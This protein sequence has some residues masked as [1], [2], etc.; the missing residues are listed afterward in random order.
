MKK[1]NIGGQAVIEGVMMKS[2]D[3]IAIAVRRSDGTIQVDAKSSKPLKEKYPILGWPIVRGAVAFIE[4]MVTGVSSLMTS[5]ELYGDEAEEEYQPSKFEKFLADKFGK[6]V[7]N[8]MI[9]TS[10]VLAILFATLLFIVLPTFITNFL[11]G[12]I[13]SSVGMNL[14]EG[15]VRLLIFL[16]YIISISQIKDI[17]RVFEYHGAEHKTIHCYEHG[18]ELVVEN[19]RKYTT[20]HPRCGTAFLLIVMVVSIILFSFLGWGNMAMR[21]VIRILLM[22]LVAGLSYEIIRWAGKSQSKLVNI[23]MFPGLM[24]QKLTTKEPDDAQL[25]VAI[26]AFLAAMDQEEDIIDCDCCKSFEPST[27]NPPS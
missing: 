1:C 19:A 21:V 22:P 23:V 3:K 15:L 27:E 24:L 18:E 26:Q 13:S 11:K 9:T 20:L 10:V 2:P 5:A 17:R 16:I 7:E 6:N 14:A 8:V 4:S 12:W 25:E